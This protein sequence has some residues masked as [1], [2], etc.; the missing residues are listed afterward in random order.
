MLR[1]MFG[2]AVPP[3]SHVR[4]TRWLSD[5]WARG[6]YVYVA[7]GGDAAATLA[8]ARPL[9]KGRLRFAGEGTCRRM[10]A[11]MHGAYVSAMREVAALMAEGG[12]AKARLTAAQRRWPLLS[13]A[14]L[15]EEECS[16][17]ASEQEWDE[18]EEE[19]DDEEEADEG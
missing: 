2:P 11:T 4:V 5:T 9:G 12:R 15:C 8:L 1:L 13:V 19:A 18:E 10:Y 6:S 7:Q 14:G 17:C 3:P 16:Q